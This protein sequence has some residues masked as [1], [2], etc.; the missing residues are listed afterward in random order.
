MGR[1]DAGE[2]APGS[3]LHEVHLVGVPVQLFL[4]ARQHHDDLMREFAVLALAH[5]DENASDPPQLRRLV[6]EIGAHS[7]APPERPDVEE[8]A[9]AGLPSVDL[10]LRVTAGILTMADHFERL[11]KS[12][13]DFC[14]QGRMLTMPRSPE[15]LRFAGWWFD[16]IRRQIAGEAPTPWTAA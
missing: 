4:A 8:A 6:R 14:A 13:D 3:T 5:E 7:A 9:Q 11:M 2:F 15:V 10:T 16:E 12:A 1:Y